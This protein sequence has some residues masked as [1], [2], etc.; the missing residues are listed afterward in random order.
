LRKKGDV[1][2]TNTN[3][4]PICDYRLGSKYEEQNTCYEDVESECGVTDVGTV[5]QRGSWRKLH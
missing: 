4:T 5:R 3:K 2:E 1:P